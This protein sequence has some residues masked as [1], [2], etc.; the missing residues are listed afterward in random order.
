M[1]GNVDEIPHKCSNLIL[2]KYV[3]IDFKLI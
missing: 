2:L 1:C 3:L